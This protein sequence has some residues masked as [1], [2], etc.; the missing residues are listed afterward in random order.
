MMNLNFCIKLTLSISVV[1]M[2]FH[3]KAQNGLTVTWGLQNTE[4]YMEKKSQDL[5]AANNFQ[6]VKNGKEYRDFVPGKNYNQVITPLFERIQDLWKK[7]NTSLPKGAIPTKLEFVKFARNE[8]PYFAGEATKLAPVLYFDFIGQSKEYILMSITIT[9]IRFDEYMGGGFSMSDAWYDIE[10]KHKKG[11]FTY[12]VE[13]KLRFTG[14]G[15]AELRFWSDNY[16]KQNGMTPSG[17]Y[18]INIRFNFLVDGKLV[19]VST[20]MFKIDV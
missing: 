5:T 18:N 17:E 19:S 11:D 6:P 14:S 7:F 8:D 13:K 4:Y 2:A 9:T 10:L 20:G 3:T 16:S 15:R 12:N 1:M